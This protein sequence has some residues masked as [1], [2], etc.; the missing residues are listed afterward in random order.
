MVSEFP[1]W[2]RKA[3]KNAWFVNTKA[4]LIG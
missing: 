3:A 2:V 1:A 4:G